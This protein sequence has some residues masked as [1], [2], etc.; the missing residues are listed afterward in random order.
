MKTFLRSFTLLLSIFLLSSNFSEAAA[1][2]GTPAPHDA[3]YDGDIET[4]GRAVRPVAESPSRV[5]TRTSF[6]DSFRDGAYHFLAGLND[7]TL[8]AFGLTNMMGG[9]DEGDLETDDRTALVEESVS[10]SKT[11]K[12]KISEESCL[13]KT[14]RH[15]SKSNYT[16]W[17]IGSAAAVAIVGGTI[18]FLIP[19]EEIPAGAIAYGHGR[20]LQETSTSS[21]LTAI[22]IGGVMLGNLGQDAW[23]FLAGFLSRRNAPRELWEHASLWFSACSRGVNHVYEEITPDELPHNIYTGTVQTL[24][25]LASL[26]ESLAPNRSTPTTEI[27]DNGRKLILHFHRPVSPSDDAGSASGTLA[28]VMT[29]KRHEKPVVNLGLNVNHLLGRKVYLVRQG[30]D[31][32]EDLLFNLIPDGEEEARNSMRLLLEAVTKVSPTRLG[33]QAGRTVREVRVSTKVTI[34]SE[35]DFLFIHFLGPRDVNM[36]GLKGDYLVPDLSFYIFNMLSTDPRGKGLV[37]VDGLRS[38]DSYSR[39]RN[40][41]FDSFIDTSAK[42]GNFKYAMANQSIS[43]LRRGVAG[44]SGVSFIG[45]PL[46]HVDAKSAAPDFSRREPGL[47][48]ESK[49][50]SGSDNDSVKSVDLRPLTSAAINPLGRSRHRRGR[51]RVRAGETQSDFHGIGIRSLTDSK[52]GKKT[53]KNSR[54]RDRRFSQF[55]RRDR[56]VSISRTRPATGIHS[57]GELISYESDSASEHIKRR[58]ESAL[59][60]AQMLALREGATAAMSGKFGNTEER[61]DGAGVG[62]GSPSFAEDATATRP[63]PTVSGSEMNGLKGEDLDSASG[64]G[65]VSAAMA[66]TAE[67]TSLDSPPLPLGAAQAAAGAKESDAGNQEKESKAP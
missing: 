55:S 58:E 57:E 14:K 41:T 5:R 36:M 40:A 39:R 30:D 29:I 43:R 50:A 52:E 8:G 33:I 62:R 51:G 59:R 15:W 12:I 7:R 53:R 28:R 9:E 65:A 6:C 67:D 18:Y 25:K 10:P 46:S 13:S 32:F 31:R 66:A 17:L 16:R 38:L 54:Q 61:D 22:G 19:S 35:R 42:V 4:G 34:P 2:G 37:P 11:R 64:I 21:S 56:P 47:I 60:A 3:R 23:R 44:A 24:G 26:A 63:G 45:K 27:M 20:F 1:L 49:A 48:A